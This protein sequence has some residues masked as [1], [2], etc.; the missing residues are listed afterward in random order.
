[1]DSFVRWCPQRP[2]AYHNKLLDDSELVVRRGVLVSRHRFYIYGI[3]K[4]D[5]ITLVLKKEIE[6]E[7]AGIVAIH[8]NS[9]V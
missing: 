7:G 9:D 4:T 8:G 6:D 5:L 2:F 1:M 3:F